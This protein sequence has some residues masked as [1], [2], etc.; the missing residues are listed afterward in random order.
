MDLP[1]P[2][3]GED[4]LAAGHLGRIRQW[5]GAR[6][7]AELSR[8]LRERVAVAERDSIPLLQV[9]ASSC[10]LQLDQYLGRHSMLPFSCFWVRSDPLLGGAASRWAQPIVSRERF[11]N[12]VRLPVFC[13]GCASDRR[14]CG[15]YSIWQRALQLPGLQR[16]AQHGCR[17]LQAQTIDAFMQQPSDIL[18]SG[19]FDQLPPRKWA[20]DHPAVS[21]FVEFGQAMLAA[22]RSWSAPVVRAVLANQASLHGLRTSVVGSLPLVSDLAFDSLP[23]PF[24]HDHLRLY[25]VRKRGVA[26]PAIDCT[27]TK[28]ENVPTGTAVAI[29]MSLLYESPREAFDA[30]AAENRRVLM[31]P[32]AQMSPDQG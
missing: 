18:V 27:V 5:I 22:G 20:A 31:E 32:A 6:S 24:I 13:P 19:R 17:L 12:P 1:L 8:A 25:Q 29:T 26:V 15:V 21:K 3:R 7:R 30:L 23:A 10:G 11:L 14:S 9:V 4:E 2:L 16:C 28:G